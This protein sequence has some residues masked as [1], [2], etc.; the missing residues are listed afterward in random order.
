[1]GEIDLRKNKKLEI[2]GQTSF[3]A[4]TERHCGVWVRNNLVRSCQGFDV[5]SGSWQKAKMD[6]ALVSA[7]NVIRDSFTEIYSAQLGCSI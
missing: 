2:S 3:K 5:D 7:L 4:K 1:M 6:V